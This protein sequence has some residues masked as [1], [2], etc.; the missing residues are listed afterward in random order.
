MFMVPTMLLSGFGT[1]I[2]NMPDWLQPL[3][4]FIP[5]SHFF[6]IIK[7]IFLKNMPALEVLT[8]VWPI[9]FIAIFTLSIAAWMF[10][11]RLE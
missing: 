11:Q 7:G 2:E 3:T 6:I 9:A 10:K 4:W 5:I 1:P 8:H